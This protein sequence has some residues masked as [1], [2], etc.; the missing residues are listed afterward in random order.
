MKKGFWKAFL[1]GLGIYIIATLVVI[2][3]KPYLD[4]SDSIWE[5]L[6]LALAVSY[7]VTYNIDYSKIEMKVSLRTQKIIFYLY[8]SIIIF[9]IYFGLS[10][11]F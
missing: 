2:G 8:A 6:T 11:L 5:A 7:M 9:L 3:I 1:V 10:Y 4:V